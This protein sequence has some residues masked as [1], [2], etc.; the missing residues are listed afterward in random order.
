M[1]NILVLFLVVCLFLVAGCTTTQQH[2]LDSDSSQVQLRSIQTRA[3]DTT[4]KEKTLRTVIS[5]L[6]DLGFVL[7]K[8]DATLGT[9]SATKLSNYALRMTVTVRPRGETQLLVRANAQYNVKP[10]T[11]PEPYQQF[12]ASL[13]KAM[14]LTAHQAD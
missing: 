8:A 2:L 13:G 14:F 5:T 9:V 6:Q 7:D 10:V 4:D 11:D 12:F 3:F 1:R